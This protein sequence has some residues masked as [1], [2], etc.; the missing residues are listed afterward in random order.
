MHSMRWQK[1]RLLDAVVPRHP[2]FGCDDLVAG[3]TVELAAWSHC[4][5]LVGSSDGG[6]SFSS[7]PLR[8][9]LTTTDISRYLNTGAKNSLKNSKKF[10]VN[11]WFTD[12]FLM[13]TYRHFI[14]SLSVFHQWPIG[15]V[16]WI[17]W[18]FP[19]DVPAWWWC[20]VGSNYVQNLLQKG[21]LAVQ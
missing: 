12:F 18:V 11:Q 14:S 8:R 5:G 17:T 9:C 1:P 13:P 7:C 19:A 15:V 3:I 6:S 10:F 4:L 20:F 21:T 16:L 2:A